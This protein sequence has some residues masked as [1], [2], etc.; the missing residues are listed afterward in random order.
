[1]RRV[2][3]AHE[4]KEDGSSFNASTG[5]PELVASLLGAGYEVHE[6]FDANGDGPP[7]VGYVA[8]GAPT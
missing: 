6:P 7:I 2:L 4:E 8:G 5:A 3:A 1:M